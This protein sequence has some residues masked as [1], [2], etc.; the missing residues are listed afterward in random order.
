[1]YLITLYKSLIGSNVIMQ[2]NVLQIR[3][4]IVDSKYFLVDLNFDVKSASTDH[5]TKTIDAH[6]IGTVLKILNNHRCIFM[7][8]DID[9]EVFLLG[10]SIQQH[11]IL[12]VPPDSTKFATY[13]KYF[14]S[15]FDMNTLSIFSIGTHSSTNQHA[16]GIFPILYHNAHLYAML[17]LDTRLPQ[18]SDFGGGFDRVYSATSHKKRDGYKNDVLGQYQ[19]QN[20]NITQEICVDHILN[21]ESN[22]RSEF[23]RKLL[24][25]GVGYGDINT[26]YTAFREFIEETSGRDQTGRVSLPFAMHT[27]FQKLFVEKEYIHLKCDKSY[28]YDTYMVF[29][30]ID[31][32]D[33]KDHQKLLRQ[34]SLIRTSPSKYLNEMA[35]PYRKMPFKILAKSIETFRVSIPTKI[36][37]NPIDTTETSSD[38]PRH[39]T[40]FVNGMPDMSI[41]GRLSDHSTTCKTTGDTRD[42]S[43]NM[44]QHI[45]AGYTI[46]G[47][48]EMRRMDLFPLL[49]LAQLVEGVNYSE[50]CSVKMDNSPEIKKGVNI[51]VNV[52]SKN[53]FNRYGR[54]NHSVKQNE[55]LAEPEYKKPDGY[56]ATTFNAPI[57]DKMRPSFADA[58]AK[59]NGVLLNICATFETYKDALLKPR[60]ELRPKTPI[61]I[62]HDESSNSE[63]AETE[64]LQM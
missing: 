39:F 55:R 48:S 10:Q 30:T 2:F 13:L 27:V 56:H 22:K 34:I 59:Y 20:G 31:D 60:S 8:F 37:G 35:K 47:N 40:N 19:I 18:Y 50:Y 15:V 41:Y 38:I 5:T 16:A 43:F 28:G 51:N 52:S 11:Q 61:N 32:F 63:F 57:Y 21:L 44:Y 4:W 45:E 25:G 42:T 6:M 64:T 1:M 33:Q 23:L 54:F 12:R 49:E 46:Q 36:D 14:I 62:D 24:K 9:H 7:V 3:Y 53:R 17:G 58:L 26:L 29:F